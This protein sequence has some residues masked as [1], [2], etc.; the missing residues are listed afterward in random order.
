MGDIRRLGFAC[1]HA[2]LPLKEAVMARA[3]SRGLEIADYGA[4]SADRVDYNDYAERAAR[5]VVSGEVDAAVLVCGTGLGMS[6]TAN[7]VRGVRCAAVSD[8]YTARMAKAHNNANAL[9][10]GARVV[11]VDLAKMIV[12]EWL[13]AEYEPRH[14][15]RLDKLAGLEARERLS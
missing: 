15:P 3:A 14:Q 11:G 12:D 4:Y 7:K 1:D 6:M 9:A 5:A 8:P 13:D 2:G 10:I